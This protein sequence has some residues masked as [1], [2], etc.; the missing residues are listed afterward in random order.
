MKING[1]LKSFVVSAAFFESVV[2][3]Y[4]DASS[5]EIKKAKQD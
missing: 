5:H 3:N 4:C 1:F 2:W